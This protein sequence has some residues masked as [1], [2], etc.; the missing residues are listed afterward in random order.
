MKIRF[1]LNKTDNHFHWYIGSFDNIIYLELM[2]QMA[3]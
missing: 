1:I 3:L 2:L